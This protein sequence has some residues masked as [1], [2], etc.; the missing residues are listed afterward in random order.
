MRDVHCV[1]GESSQVLH[2]VPDMELLGTRFTHV[3]FDTLPIPNPP[4]PS[5]AEFEQKVQQG[6][7]LI[8]RSVLKGYV[9]STTKEKFSVLYVPKRSADELKAASLFGDDGDEVRTSG[10]GVE[11]CGDGAKT[12]STLYQAPTESKE[13]DWVRKYNYKIDDSVKDCFIFTPNPEKVRGSPRLVAHLSPLQGVITYVPIDTKVTLTKSSVPVRPLVSCNV[14]GSSQ[15]GV[16]RPR[17]SPSACRWCGR[18]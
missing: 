6:E 14:R 18:R 4:H 8:A 9:E 2:I 5:D 11:W 12:N 3:I 16:C 10:A 1:G 7:Y 17:R 13:L 15:N